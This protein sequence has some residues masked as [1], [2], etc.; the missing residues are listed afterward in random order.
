MSIAT[1]HADCSNKGG[2]ASRCGA[3]S[4]GNKGSNSSTGSK[5]TTKGNNPGLPVATLFRHVQKAYKI[6]YDHVFPN[7]FDTHR[8]GP[9]YRSGGLARVRSCPGT[10]EH[11]ADHEHADDKDYEYVDDQRIHVKVELTD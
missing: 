8:R 2:K 1:F 9:P 4:K 11:E 3:G 5:G 7:G 6:G 10:S